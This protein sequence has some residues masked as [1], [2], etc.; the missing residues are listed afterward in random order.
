MTAKLLPTAPR[1]TR[2]LRSDPWSM[3]EPAAPP[4]L[5]RAFEISRAVD[6]RAATTQLQPRQTTASNRPRI[7]LRSRRRRHVSPCCC[8]IVKDAA[9]ELQISEGSARQYLGSF[10]KDRKKRQIDL[11]RDRAYAGASLMTRRIW[12]AT[13]AR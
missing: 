10:P 7:I 5:R 11:I 2:D 3:S 12:E 6:E 1:P 8:T 13:T 9:H 4:H